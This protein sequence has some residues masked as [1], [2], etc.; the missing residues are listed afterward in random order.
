MP[1]KYKDPRWERNAKVTIRFTA[2]ELRDL[3][4]AQKKSGKHSV[5]EWLR[6]IVKKEIEGACA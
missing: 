2:Q 4:R 3:E 1:A 6:E 5:S